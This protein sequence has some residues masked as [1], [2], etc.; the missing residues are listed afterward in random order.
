MGSVQPPRTR[1][2]A[3][4]SR[5][6]SPSA[7][8]VGGNWRRPRFWTAKWAPV[9]PR[10]T[11]R[12]RP[13]RCPC[14]SARAHIGASRGSAR[15]ARTPPR[16][17]PP[18]SGR[19][20]SPPRGPHLTKH[21]CRRARS[22]VSSVLKLCDDAYQHN[23][24]TRERAIGV[25]VGSLGGGRPSATASTA[26]HTWPRR[27]ARPRT[28]SSKNARARPRARPRR[29]ASPARGTAR[30]RRE[31]SADMPQ[32]LSCARRTPWLSPRA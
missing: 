25:V 10:Q 18:C 5:S 17:A 3:R 11:T 2:G 31:P 29:P 22:V 30:T 9:R 12:T 27:R 23:P 24:G 19:R 21:T 28:C 6:S 26:R 8:S 4:A 14:C 15:V 13:R 32:L 20:L 1:R 7:F 16:R